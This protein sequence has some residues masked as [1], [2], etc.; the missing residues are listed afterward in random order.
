MD[1]RTTTDVGGY[2]SGYS[3]GS[4]KGYRFFTRQNVDCYMQFKVTTS[5]S[6]NLRYKITFGNAFVQYLTPTS[7]SATISLIATIS[8]ASPV[9][10]STTTLPPVGSAT[11]TPL[12]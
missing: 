11:F 4:T 12:S 7:G 10:L 1:N 6:N 8:G 5:I 3:S 9:T 2:T